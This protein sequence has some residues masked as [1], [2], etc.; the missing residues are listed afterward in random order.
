MKQFILKDSPFRVGSLVNEATETKDP[1]DIYKASRDI[2]K[3]KKELESKLDSMQTEYESLIKNQFNDK[4]DELV[5]TLKKV[6][7][8]AKSI[9]RVDKQSAYDGDVLV[10]FSTGNEVT[11]QVSEKKKIEDAFGE[12]TSIVA[13]GIYVKPDPKSSKY[14]YGGLAL[15]FTKA[16]QNKIRNFPEF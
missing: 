8:K 12:K 11:D 3:Q 1:M 4:L 15:R 10:L 14:L 2:L 5:V 6:Y 7:P 16:Y 9:K 13:N